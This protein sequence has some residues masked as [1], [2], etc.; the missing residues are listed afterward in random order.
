MS[1][2]SSK[3]SS[4]GSLNAFVVIFLSSVNNNDGNK[5]RFESKAIN[6]VNDIKNPIACMPPNPEK[7][8]IE[9]PNIKITE[10]YI[11]VTF[12]SLKEYIT[13]FLIFQLLNFN[14]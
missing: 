5:K 2:S 13:E 3:I 7:A 6:K 4:N 10:E 1:S 9:N 8:N 14:S 11:I 12:I